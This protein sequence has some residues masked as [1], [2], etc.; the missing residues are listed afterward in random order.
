MDNDRPPSAERRHER[1][2]W[3]A[4]LFGLAVGV[5]I[6]WLGGVHFAPRYSFHP[7]GLFIIDSHKG[8]V[9]QK[10][11][12]PGHCEPVQVEGDYEAGSLP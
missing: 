12:S 1:R 11:I 8:Q 2:A 4:G 5:V 10:E 9:W 7:R 3:T 6:G